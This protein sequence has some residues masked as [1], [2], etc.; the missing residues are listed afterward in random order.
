[1]LCFVLGT[2]PEIIKMAPLIRRAVGA[3]LPFILIHT[4]QHYDH[5]LDSVFFEELKLPQPNHN[6]HAAGSSHADM[7]SKMLIG[8]EKLWIQEKPSV[9]VVE[10]DTNSVFA[11]AFCANSLNIPVAH[12]ESG[13]RSDDWE[14]PEERNRVLT[15]RLS[16]RLYVPTEDQAARLSQEGIEDTNILITGNTIADAVAEHSEYAKQVSL[17]EGLEGILALLTLHRPALVDN[18]DRLQSVLQAIDSAL[19]EAN[20]EGVLLAHPRTASKL[21]LLNLSLT[22]IKI[23]EPIGYLPMLRL[24]QEAK[25]IITDSGGLQE[26]A[27]LLHLPCVTVRENTERPETIRAG[28]NIVTGFDTDVISKAITESLSK[29]IDWKPLYSVENP[30]D[31]I[32]DDLTT[33]YA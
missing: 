24:M 1:M 17:P 26:E 23:H 25:V 15:D 4:G 20:I 21:Q 9:V 2:R 3:N 6:L 7:I 31:T 14:M 13:L 16:Q 12:V 32:M 28:G 5:L 11:A 27:A 29:K 10:G 8:L 19:S 22:S 18:P 33:H 30:S